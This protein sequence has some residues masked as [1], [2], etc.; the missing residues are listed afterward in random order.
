ME[1]MKTLKYTL[2]TGLLMVSVMASAQIKRISG[3]VSDDFDVLPGVNVQEVDASG[4]TVSA[5]VTDMN[6]NFV[7]AIKSQKNKLKV[8]Y[9]GFKPQTL[10]INKT[11]FKIML[12]D[13][14][15]TLKDVE[16][17][18]K[19]MMKTSGLAIP[20]RE[21]SFAAQGISSKEFE[22]LG[23]TSVDEALQ[24]RIAGLD[25][26]GV[27]GD[28]GSGSQMRLRGASSISDN[29]SGQP[30]IVVNGNVLTDADMTG[31]DPNNA[32]DE[33]YAA[34]LKVNTQDIEDIKVLKDGAAA[35]IWGSQGGNGVI[36]IT[37]KRGSRGPAKVSYSFT[38]VVTRQPAGFKLL[39]GDQYTMMLKEAYFNPNQIDEASHIKEIDYP[40]HSEFPESYMF[41]NNTDWLDAVK[42]VGFRQQH[43]I[44]VS[45]GDEKTTFRL[46]GGFEN[47]SGTIIKQ[48]LQRFST[49]MA[50]DYY[51]NDRITLTSNFDMTYTKKTNIYGGIIGAAQRKMP[52]MAIYREN[53]DGVPTDDYYYA[54]QAGQGVSIA[55]YD[56][57]TAM[58]EQL[59]DQRGM[60]NIIAKQ[61]L[62]N[63]VT[64]NYKITPELILKYKLLGTNADKHQLNY[65]G[66]AYMNISND[67]A[68]EDLPRELTTANFL[69]THSAYSTS[70]KSFSFNTKHT[71]TFT[72][73]FENEDHYLTA[74]GRF[75][76]NTGNSS[77]QATNA[78]RLAAGIS[79]PSSGALLTGLSST[80]GEWRSIFWTFSTHYSWK[81]RYM[82][83]FTLRIDGTTRFG[84]NSRWGYFP[85]ISGRW[86]IIDE[87]FMQKVKEKARM[88]MLG[89]RGGWALNGN[90]PNRD[91]LYLNTYSQGPSYLG[92]TSFSPN[93]V[94]L[95]TLKWE[96]RIKWNIGMNLGFFDDMLTMDINV[97]QEKTNGMLLQKGIASSNGYGVLSHHNIGDM[98]N[99]GWEFYINGNRLFK[100]GK[101]YMDAYINFANNR[102]VITELDNATLEAR[103]I[104]L[105]K[106]NPNAS[107]IE[108]V[109]VDNPFGSIYGFRYKG[110]YQYTYD[111]AMSLKNAERE[112][113]KYPEKYAD[114]AVKNAYLKDHLPSKLYEAGVTS[115]AEAVGRGYTFPVATNANGDVMYEADGRTP[116]RMRAFYDKATN[117]TGA[118]KFEGGDAIYEDLNHDGNIDEL[119]VEHLGS[120]LPL[121]TGGFG[122][123]LHYDKWKLMA[124]FN[125]RV[126]V[127]VINLDRLRME[128]M[129]TNNNQ[130][131]AVNYRWRKNGDVTSI[132]RALNGNNNYNTMISDRF[133]EDAS[134][135]RLNYLQL[136]YSFDAKKLKK[137]G[138]N[139]LSFYISANNLFCLTKYTGIDPEFG[140]RQSGIAVTEGQ[141]P[142]AKS[143]TLGVT[144]GF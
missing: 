34:L 106:S 27:S 97:Y 73:H 58:S 75:E 56:N 133:V 135:V 21:V 108:R 129:T 142:R 144:V 49:R 101:F 51:V 82:V 119:D 123:T 86:N 130:S 124:N 77:T 137:Y 44:A 71:F 65:E 61:Y 42:Q 87:P 26:V 95:T 52:N 94:K 98:K 41:N 20:E 28:L 1:T 90:A 54:I 92:V 33:D 116:K 57:T 112:F 127:D 46:S 107:I 11:V 76:L 24:G 60:D 37:T 78:N 140:T 16:V 25:I 35:A 80:Y 70:A 126:D 110:V 131:E 48:G 114:P 132:P 17:K 12:A 59:K 89:I 36:E 139:A 79:N 67:Y 102:S 74:L 15:T 19:K 7:L 115:L 29:V 38:G 81:S 6:G 134:F 31:F 111:A 136:A 104:D 122:F 2:L 100:K 93:G 8:S 9:V 121:L 66:K 30:L 103:N 63:Y 62:A 45:G 14:T 88:N 23:I 72:P 99:T 13:N 18:A 69:D 141:T 120:S 117:N 55:G 53:V 5:T 118:Y 83:D 125:Y 91:Y 47:E 4:R 43:Y 143:Y 96:E 85:A 109:Q 40:D 10:P 32:T 39:N 22:G 113:A 128:A 50:L 84:E 3:T 105:N 138:L 64:S 68:D